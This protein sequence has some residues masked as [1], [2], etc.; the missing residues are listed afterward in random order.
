MEPDF[1]IQKLRSGGF[2]LTPQRLTIIEVLR[3]A[4]GHLS[5][6]ETYRHARER[7]PGLTEATVYRTL[8]FLTAQGVALMTHC[9]D[10]H[11]VYE[12]ADQDHHHLVCRTC[13]QMAEIEH[14]LLQDL[15]DQFMRETGFL[16][17]T[18]HLT[19][20]GQCPKCVDG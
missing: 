12:I 3:E 8:D 2:R 16:V 10:G 17:E 9:G 18:S 15:Y 19:F 13:G 11:L 14:S 20:F 6:Q 4:G 7:L 1:D 5:A